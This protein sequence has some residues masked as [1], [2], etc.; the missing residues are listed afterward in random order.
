M[1]LQRFDDVAA[2]YEQVE[3]FLLEQEAENCLIIGLCHELARG[4]TYGPEPPYMACV[5]EDSRVMAAALRTPPHNLNLSFFAPPQALR[6]IAQD[7]QHHFGTLPGVNSEAA[8]SLAF[9]QIW[10]DLTDSDY[11]LGMAQRLYKLESV[12]PVAGVPGAMRR[13]TQA[14]LELLVQ[15][16]SAFER[17]A[18]A[19]E[20]VDEAHLREAIVQRLGLDTRGLYLWEDGDPVSFA[21]VAGPTPHGI[22]IGPVYTPPEARRRGYAS[23]LTAALSQEM[24][25]SGRSFCCLYTD[26]GNPTSN[27][28]YQHIGYHPLC[29]VNLYRFS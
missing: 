22:R 27:S 1:N 21:G 15:W 25:D 26:L 14:D 6:H 8:T 11:T 29:D 17:E 3:P 24:L 4:V 9:A 2:F 13:A 18:F 16:F 12:I 19:T 10:H 5:Y 23:A 7:A 20:A 28:I